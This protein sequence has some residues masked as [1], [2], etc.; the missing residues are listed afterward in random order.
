MAAQGNSNELCSAKAKSLER[1]RHLGPTVVKMVRQLREEADDHAQTEEKPVAD[2]REFPALLSQ[3]QERVATFEGQQ[4]QQAEVL[5][6]MAQQTQAHVRRLA[7]VIGAAHVTGVCRWR[8]A[9]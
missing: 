7:S 4:M 3:L 1:H 2:S 9:D 5:S 8:G 6:K